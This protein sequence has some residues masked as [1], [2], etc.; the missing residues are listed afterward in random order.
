MRAG[1]TL[2]AVVAMVTGGELED[3][4]R[5]NFLT[6]DVVGWLETPTWR[7][8]SSLSFFFKSPGDVDAEDVGEQEEDIAE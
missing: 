2:A 7:S 4:L 5:V 3:V 8:K 6:L 1:A